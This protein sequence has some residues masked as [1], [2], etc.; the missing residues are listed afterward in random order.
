MV[1]AGFGSLL[2]IVVHLP[3]VFLWEYGALKSTWNY[4][5]WRNI[6]FGLSL[7]SFQ[8]FWFSNVFW[9][10]IANDLVGWLAHLSPSWLQLDLGPMKFGKHSYCLDFCFWPPCLSAN[11]FLVC[12]F[13]FSHWILATDVNHIFSNIWGE[14]HG[15]SPNL[16]RVDYSFVAS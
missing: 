14:F 6:H 7:H 8:T 16:F 15:G 1:F 10:K 11:Y 13:P 5:W 3:L 12:I 4:F 9:I 2:D